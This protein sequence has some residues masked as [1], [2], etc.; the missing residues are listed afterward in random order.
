MSSVYFLRT[1]PEIVDLAADL[2]SKLEVTVHNTGNYFFEHA[3]SKHLSN[4][5][6]VSSIAELPDTDC[7]LVLSMSNFISPFTD[8]GSVADEI[9]KKNISRIVMIGAGAQADDYNESISLTRGTRRFLDIL[10]ERSSS[11][12]VRGVYTA[13]VL[14]R[15]GI[16]NVDVIGCPSI[17]FNC[18][19]AFSI[20][21]KVRN[22]RKIKSAFH[23]TPSGFYRDN[24]A[25]LIA[26]GIKNSESYIAQS[27]KELFGLHSKIK[28]EQEFTK[29]FFHYYNDGAISPTES[30]D[31]FRNNTRWFFDLNSWFEY[32]KNLDFTFGARFHGNMA[33]ILLGVPALNMVFDTRTRE[34]CEYLNLPYMHLKDF[35]SDMTIN[36]LYRKADFSLFN[37]TFP[38]KYKTYRDFL[39]KNGLDVALPDV[40][41]TTSIS[42]SCNAR[43]VHQL[44][45]DLLDSGAVHSHIERELLLRFEPF[46]DASERLSVEDGIFARKMT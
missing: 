16:R 1:V 37:H 14:A 39:I 28:Q 22:K 32:M 2:Q 36:D 12:G 10:S 33:G 6:T 4:Y 3:V 24:I 42:A 9:E 13:E 15:L 17:F 18:D 26:F 11:I 40:S 38:V 31:W 20:K 7:T 45:D 30:Q 8:L 25:S 35:N 5:L 23:C 46:R 27:E 43:A 21:S 34:M 29:F 44:I 19:P 41:S